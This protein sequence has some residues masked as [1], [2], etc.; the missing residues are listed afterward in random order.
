MYDNI[1][2]ETAT[3]RFNHSLLFS[4]IE[5]ILDEQGD[6]SCIRIYRR[7]SYIGMYLDLCHKSKYFEPRFFCKIKPMIGD[8]K[9]KNI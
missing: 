4:D 8:S 1:D 2:F 6:L 7:Y 9:D 5:R 3:S